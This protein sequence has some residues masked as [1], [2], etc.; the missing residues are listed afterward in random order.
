MLIK[1]LKKIWDG[2]I[3][4]YPNSS[5]YNNSKNLESTEWAFKQVMQK[6]KFID[7]AK[8]WI[9]LGVDFI[10]GCCGVNVDHIKEL[11]KIIK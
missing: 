7:Y 3:G 11:K 2:L 5:S 4:V 9:D 8:T 10:G 1:E 6:E